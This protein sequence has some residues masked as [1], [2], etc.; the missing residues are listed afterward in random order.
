MDDPLFE[1]EGFATASLREKGSK[2]IACL[3]PVKDL[4]ESDDIRKKLQKEYYDSTHICYAVRIGYGKHLLEKS[5]D[6]GEPPNTAGPPILNALREKKLTNC[7]MFVIRYFGGT[8]LGT[9]GLIKS[10]RGCASLAIDVANLKESFETVNCI[11]EVSYPI[12]GQF[13]FNLAKVSGRILSENKEMDGMVV[14]VEII[15]NNKV[16]FENYLKEM[17]EKWKNQLKWKWK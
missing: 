17:S 1:P 12:V 8:K 3:F 4:K 15:K 11:V 10:Y 13:L 2:F 16:T 9:S 7:A 5:S 14:E 6:S